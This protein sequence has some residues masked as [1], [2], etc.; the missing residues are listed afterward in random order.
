M[1]QWLPTLLC[2]LA[3]YLIARA[4]TPWAMRLAPSIGAIDTP[5]DGRRMHSRPIPR[6]GGLAMFAAFI[7]CISATGTLYRSAVALLA[8]GTLIV[9]LGLFDDVYRLPA[10]LK[11]IVQL[12]ASA[13][14]LGYGTGAALSRFPAPLGFAIGVLY[15]TLLINAHNMIDGLDGLAAGVGMLES[16]ALALIFGLQGLASDA[17]LALTLGGCSLG[18]LHWNR[19]PARVFMGDTGSQLIGYVLGALSLRVEPSSTPLGI[20]S[21]ALI[22]ALPLSDLGFAVVRRTLRGHSPFEA[23][24][25][26]WHHRLVDAGLSQRRACAWLCLLSALC[27]SAG[28]LLR[29]V[30]WYPFAV[31][32]LL[33]ALGLVMLLDLR[34][35]R[36]TRQE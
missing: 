36:P 28:I 20:L 9:L 2:G 18:F 1:Y 3:A 11:L 22:F 27:A 29:R 21:L 4:L 17:S 30:S 35:R 33:A 14:A 5:R 32:T 12:I 24:R 7:L 25:G 6:T 15:L 23:D 8:G 19:H 26:H 16:I 31:Y 10:P 13:V 34:L